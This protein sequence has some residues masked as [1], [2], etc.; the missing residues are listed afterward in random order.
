MKNKKTKTKTKTNEITFATSVADLS[1]PKEL[2]THLNGENILTVAKLR[3]EKLILKNEITKAQYYLI[4]CIIEEAIKTESLLSELNACIHA[5]CKESNFRNLIDFIIYQVNLLGARK[6]EIMKDRMGISE[7]SKTLEEIGDKFNLSRER[8]R[9]I[10][11]DA[12]KELKSNT[13]WFNLLNLKLQFLSL[14]YPL[15]K[16]STVKKDS[17]IGFSE[18][19][20]SIFNYLVSHKKILKDNYH[21]IEKETGYLKFPKFISILDME[22]WELIFKHTKGIFNEN[23]F[24][25][26]QPALFQDVVNNVLNNPAISDIVSVNYSVNDALSEIIK[27]E[28]QYAIVGESKYFIGLGKTSQTLIDKLL[29][30]SPRAIHFTEIPALIKQKHDIDINIAQACRVLGDSCFAILNGN[31]KHGSIFNNELKISDQKILCDLIIEL[32]EEADVKD[33]YQWCNDEIVSLLKKS[34]YQDNPLVVNVSRYHVS[35]ALIGTDKLTY[36]KRGVYVLAKS[37]KGTKRKHLKQLIVDILKTTG[38]VM[39]VEEIK[40]EIVKTRSLSR[41][42]Q[43]PNVKI[44]KSLN[45]DKVDDGYFYITSKN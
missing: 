35:T 3:S 26:I 7:K 18:E 8:V 19:N 21:F 5:V 6:A 43:M 23:K 10:E 9:Q 20:E 42:F 4:E 34:K 27:N 17:I 28:M 16:T 2:L 40:A 36:L 25:N 44:L 12:I 13:N 22:K 45:I 38:N 31:G 14:Q 1:I 33:D 37:S 30:E 32:I 29:I 11:N 39:S 15:L 24:R 41:F